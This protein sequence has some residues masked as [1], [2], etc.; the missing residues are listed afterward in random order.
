ML[1]EQSPFLGK[2]TIAA[3][4]TRF[5]LVA[6]ENFLK[7]LCATH[8]LQLPT[9]L[10]CSSFS[11]GMGLT[12]KAWEKEEL[13]DGDIID[14]V[15]PILQA[16]PNLKELALLVASTPKLEEFIHTATSSSTATASKE[17]SCWRNRRKIRGHND[18]YRVKTIGVDIS[19]A[20]ATSILQKSRRSA[21][22]AF[23]LLNN[24]CF[25]PYLAAFAWQIPGENRRY[26]VDCLRPEEPG[27]NAF[28]KV[29]FDRD[30]ISIDLS[31]FRQAILNTFGSVPPINV[32]TQLKLRKGKQANIHHLYTSQ[33][34][35]F[36]TATRRRIY[37]HGD[38]L[39]KC[40]I[41]HLAWELDVIAGFKPDK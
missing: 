17:P 13:G 37:K 11:E 35:P 8:S 18:D 28:I 7:L 9:R 21:A 38:S 30:L 4:S 14:F 33:Q 16:E 39:D 23:R 1:L 2:P 31:H 36:C 24:P 15:R 25:A 6:L 26:M 27:M 19:V 22:V 12:V 34:R 3:H 40:A 32:I 10:F 20:E 29:L 5:N 41:Y